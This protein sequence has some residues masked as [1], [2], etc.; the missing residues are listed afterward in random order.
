MYARHQA[1]LAELTQAVLTGAD[2]SVL[3][4]QA[5]TFVADTLAV[6]YSAIW[7]YL[8][9]RGILVLRFGV[10]WREN[11]MDGTTIQVAA[12]SP[13]GSSVLSA[14]PVIVADWRSETHFSQP[15]LLRGHG[16]ISS[17]SVVI[18]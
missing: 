9:E 12:T 3:M 8:P 4:R 14:I 2:L 16:V 11:G 7:E 10:G 15:P 18:P 1:A 5:V 13:I 6:A 17:V